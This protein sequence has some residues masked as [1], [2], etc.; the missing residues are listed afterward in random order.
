MRGG[1]VSR[2]VC[3]SGASIGALQNKDESQAQHAGEEYKISA[4]ATANVDELL[5]K[6]ADDESLRRYKVLSFARCCVSGDNVRKQ[7]MDSLCCPSCLVGCV[8][9]RSNCSAL[10]PTATS[11]IRMTPAASS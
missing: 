4:A 2:V 5:N 9:Y 10:L 8:I 6:D 1:F 7:R 11:V 3:E